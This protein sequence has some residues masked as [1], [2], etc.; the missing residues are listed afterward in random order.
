MLGCPGE[1]LNSGNK[2]NSA[3]T[4]IALVVSLSVS[5][6]LCS[7]CTWITNLQS[8]LQDGCQTVSCKLYVNYTPHNRKGQPNVEYTHHRVCPYHCV[9]YSLQPSNCILRFSHQLSSSHLNKLGVTFITSQ[10]SLACEFTPVDQNNRKPLLQTL[11][12]CTA[13]CTEWTS[14][15]CV[16]S[17]LQ[18]LPRWCGHL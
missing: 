4:S 17:S 7:V 10:C 14:H 8:A 16:D 13:A 15:H 9:V 18:R 12:S 11:E 2:I 1:K 5:F 6:Q 3:A